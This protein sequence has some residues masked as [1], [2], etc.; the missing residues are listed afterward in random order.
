M[1]TNPDF[2]H[3][4][5]ASEQEPKTISWPEIPSTLEAAAEYENRL[6]QML[7]ALGWDEEAAYQVSY[8]FQELLKNAIVHGNLGLKKE[9]GE[10]D[11]DWSKKVMTTSALDENKSKV[12]SVNISASPRRATITIQDMGKDTPEFWTKENEARGMRTG[13]DTK[14]QSGRGVMIS[15]AFLNQVTYAKNDTGIKATLFRNL[16]IPIVRKP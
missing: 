5:E 4:P 8:A 7:M 12:V 14:W 15:E 2:P 13:D 3:T 16:D 10:Q 6:N 11:E 9:P 1:S